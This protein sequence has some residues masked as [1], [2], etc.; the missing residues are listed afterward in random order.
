MQTSNVRHI[1]RQLS[2]EV[3]TCRE[4]VSYEAGGAEF[5][6]RG[7]DVALTC[8]QFVRERT[9]SEVRLPSQQSAQ[10][11]GDGGVRCQRVEN[12]SFTRKSTGCLRAEHQKKP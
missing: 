6:Q 9:R 4:I 2:M 5:A 11:R 1:E 10:P 12:L 3:G 8:L 7:P